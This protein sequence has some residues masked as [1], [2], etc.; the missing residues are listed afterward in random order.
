MANVRVPQS[1]IE[2]LVSQTPNIRVQQS[3]IELLT[4]PG[5]VTASC[6]N[7]PN[8]LVG[9][10]Y[11]TTFT[12]SGGT[13]PVTWA[14]FSGAFPTGLSLNSATG[15]LS[16]IPT[17]AG[18]YVFTLQLTDALSN[19]AVITCSIT[20]GTAP[21]LTCNSPPNGTVGTFYSHTFGL[22]GGT[23]PYTLALI[24]GSFPPGLS[25]PS[26][27][28]F[29]E[30]S[31]Y[32]VSTL[33]IAGGIGYQSRVHSPYRVTFFSLPAEGILNGTP[34]APGTYTFTLQLT[35]S[36]GNT[37]TVTCTIIINGQGGSPCQSGGPG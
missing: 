17:V 2:S 11:S 22:S 19:Q 5:P 27:N 1:A 33:F 28:Q 7:P 31:P 24:S 14:L 37:S 12:Q 26:T 9:Q 6:N 8:G 20:I 15:V 25:M 13:L 21:V 10:A 16:G 34:T 30:G 32:F 29:V 3:A 18:T 23:P 36:L 4:I 35:D